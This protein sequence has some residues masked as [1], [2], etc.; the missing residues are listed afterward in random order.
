MST[1]YRYGRSLRLIAC[2][3]SSMLL[4]AC[5]GGQQALQLG[6]ERMSHDEAKITARMIDVIKEVSLQRHAPGEVK[7]FNQA[8]SLG[9]FNASFKVNDDLPGKL[10]QGVFISGKE[11]AAKIR[12]AN[13][14][15]FDDTEKDF[16]GLSIKLF[17]VE[18]ET[19][20]GVN[21]QQD[22]LLNS[23]PALFAANPEDFLDFIEATRDEKVW[24]YFI[25]PAHFYSLKVVLSGRDKI[26]NPFNIRYW[27]T[28]PYRLGESQ[29]QA[30]KYSVKSCASSER[31]LKVDQHEHFL[32]EV[33]TR[34]LSQQVACFDFMLQFQKD[35][36]SMP[37]E[38]ASVVWDEE[39]SPFIK[40]AS[41]IIKQQSFTS[42]EN[43]KACEVMTFNP[44]QSTVAHKPI[45]GI[46][47]VRKPVYSE[48]AN[49]RHDQNNN[50]Q[51]F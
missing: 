39:D 13:A 6:E 35:P 48:I 51:N 50:R 1:R 23:H 4:L 45:G 41:I 11:Y 43:S 42:D 33:M 8:K 9:C 25:N 38:D 31:P 15:K 3:L 12:F 7:R 40:V 47:R 19:L 16:R 27:S 44:W 17:D 29:S 30:I 26:D 20:W 36:E 34:H 32:T 49:F 28:T 21:G 18:G 5:D 37:I 24:Q 2:A 22:F 10:Q 46:N 14:T